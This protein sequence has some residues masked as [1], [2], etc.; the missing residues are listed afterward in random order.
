MASWF[1]LC[2]GITYMIVLI[3]YRETLELLTPSYVPWKIWIKFRQHCSNTMGSYRKKTSF[4]EYGNWISTND[5][6]KKNDNKI[7]MKNNG[8]RIPLS[9]IYFKLSTYNRIPI[10]LLKASIW[11]MI[12]TQNTIGRQKIFPIVP[13]PQI[14]NKINLVFNSFYQ[15]NT[16]SRN[17]VSGR[18]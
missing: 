4:V 15:G 7:S 6:T 1:D 11:Y 16:D 8:I 9:K 5:K 13:F 17:M 18:I 2:I 3:E 12:W 14:G 10:R